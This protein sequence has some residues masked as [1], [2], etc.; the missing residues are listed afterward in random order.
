MVTVLSFLPWLTIVFSFL[1]FAVC[2]YLIRKQQRK[3][4]AIELLIKSLLVSNAKFKKEFSEIH[5]GAV[6]MGKKVQ[7][8]DGKIKSTLE[9]QQN[10][11][12]QAPENRLYTRAMKMVE[13]GA[14]IEEIIEECELPKAEAELLLNLHKK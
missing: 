12:A 9:N 2:F 3:I 10:L 14:S 4:K 11:A 6:G 8:L 1:L 5:T 7:K 13:L